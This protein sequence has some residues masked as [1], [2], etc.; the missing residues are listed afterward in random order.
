MLIFDIETGPLPEERLRELLPPFDES[1]VDVVTGEFDPATV[2]CGNIGGPTSEKGKAKIEEARKAHEAAK[3]LS[4]TT[5]AVAK[6]EHWLKF[7]ERAALSAATGRVLAI[8]YLASESG[9]FAVDHGDGDEL[10]LLK[11]FWAKYAECR[12]QQRKMV[13]HHRRAFD[14]PFLIRR[15]WILE[16]DV[17]VT[18]IE[19]G[20]YLDDI[21]ADTESVWSCGTRDSISLDDLSLALGTG[22]KPDGVNGAMFHKLWFGT[23]DE[24]AAA[25]EYLVND[26]RL[27]AADAVKM[28]LI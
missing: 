25:I 2:K 19:Q 20:R 5:I 3:S 1:K 17:P 6:E 10:K 18:V 7:V 28:G 13:G 14:V 22:K 4:A 23:Q 15:S 16:V 26:L 24:R 8:G 21:F 27:T 12:Q 9:K 11:S